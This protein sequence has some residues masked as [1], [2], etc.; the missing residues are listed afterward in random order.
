MAGRILIVDDEPHQRRSL[1]FGL[2]LEGFEVDQAVAAQEAL[3]KLDFTGY[4]LAIV[5]LMMPGFNGLELVRRMRFRHPNVMVVLTSAYHLSEVQLK[6]I[7][8]DAIAFVPKP[9]SLEDLSGYLR[10]RLERAGIA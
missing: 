8:L 5:D 7:G 10:D 9:Y 6:K 4:D 1:T 2:S 3:A